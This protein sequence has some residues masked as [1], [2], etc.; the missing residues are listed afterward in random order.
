MV[1][2]SVTLFEVSFVMQPLSIDVFNGKMIRYLI[3][4]PL[5]TFGK[6]KK[7]RDLKWLFIKIVEVTYVVT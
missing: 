1:L 5:K 6:K 3:I 4:L 7:K 2:K